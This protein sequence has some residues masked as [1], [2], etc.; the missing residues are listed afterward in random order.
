MRHRMHIVVCVFV[1]V[2][3]LRDDK[4]RR[5]KSSRADVSDVPTLTAHFTE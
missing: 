5:T 1:S 2:F 3:M 4:K